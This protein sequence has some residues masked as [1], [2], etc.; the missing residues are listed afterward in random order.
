MITTSHLAHS[1]IKNKSAVGRGWGWKGMGRLETEK[2]GRL[3][4]STTSKVGVATQ[5]E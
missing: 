1:K 4:C 2:M 3:K 5:Q